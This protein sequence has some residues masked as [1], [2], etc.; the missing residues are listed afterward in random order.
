[1]AYLEIVNVKGRERVYPGMNASNVKR[2]TKR[3]DSVK[4]LLNL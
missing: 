4:K 3:P 1:M 2:E